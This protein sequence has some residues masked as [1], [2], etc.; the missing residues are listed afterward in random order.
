MQHLLSYYS[1]FARQRTHYLRQR[2][3]H[4]TRKNCQRPHQRTLSQTV[5][6]KWVL[7]LQK[8]SL[9]IAKYNQSENAPKTEGPGEL[10]DEEPEA[11]TRQ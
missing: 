5:C 7:A 1:A 9:A 6:A 3:Y 11:A 4:S 2:P 10:D 8:L